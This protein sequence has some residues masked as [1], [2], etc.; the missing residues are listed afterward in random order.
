MNVVGLF[1]GIGG[2]ELGFRNV[3][4]DIDVVS[5][6]DEFPYNSLERNF[7]ESI[8][9]DDVAKITKELVGDVDVICGG[10]PCQDISI[11]SKT[12]EGLDG[13]RSGLW[14]EFKRIINE[15][16]P[17]YAVIE[18]VFMLKTRGLDKVLTDLA[19][20]G[21]DATYTTFDSQYFG[22]PQRRR[23]IYILAVRDGI[24]KDADIFDFE[25]RSSIECRQE[26]DNFKKSLQWDFQ[27]IGEGEQTFTYYTRQRSD[28][29]KGV[30]LSST[31]LKR[32]YKD[33]M[34]LIVYEDGVRRVTP[35]ERLLLQ[36]FPIDWLDNIDGYTNTKAFMN[37]G[38]TVPVIEHIGEC[39]KQFDK[40]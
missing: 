2:F 1:S 37:Q 35:T 24:P 8:L 38:M 9:L 12:A 39:I 10:F 33:F 21:Y 32:D 30:G 7:P 16:R 4:F 18:N 26:V 15:V 11:A 13:Q 14:N 34:D 5:E 36:G 40:Y 28:Q 20:I 22:V 27:K 31:L 3:G 17:R 23:R 29:F 19:K 25:G 6:C